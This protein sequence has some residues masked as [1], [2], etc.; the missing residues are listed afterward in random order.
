M[1]ETE[2]VSCLF[3]LLSIYSEKVKSTL[4][5][6]F[7]LHCNCAIAFVHCAIMIILFGQQ[8]FEF[9]EKKKITLKMA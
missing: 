4:L 3:V 1:I 9:E 8:D 7:E 6:I 5:S 2:S